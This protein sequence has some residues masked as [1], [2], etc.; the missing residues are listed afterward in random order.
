MN[1]IKRFL[2]FY[3]SPKDRLNSIDFSKK[4]GRLF[5]IQFCLWLMLAV[6]EVLSDLLGKP[7]LFRYVGMTILLSFY[8]HI[9]FAIFGLKNAL[10]NRFNDWAAKKG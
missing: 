8:L 1:I 2:D 4:I 6:Y 3:L 7:V 5:S 9:L 10:I